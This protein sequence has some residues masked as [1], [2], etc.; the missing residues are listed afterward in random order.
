LFFNGSRT[1]TGPAMPLGGRA[2]GR[3]NRVEARFLA[4]DFGPI[5]LGQFDPGDR[6]DPYV[7]GIPAQRADGDPAENASTISMIRRAGFLLVVLP[8]TMAYAPLFGQ[9]ALIRLPSTNGS[10]CYSV[11]GGATGCGAG[12]SSV[13]ADFLSAFSTFF[14]F[15]SISRCR[16]S[17]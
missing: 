14:F 11:L 6:A 3:F 12:G 16:F 9:P 15:F 13:V 8:A 5:G 10:G 2:W 17:Y 1:N 4:E 7:N